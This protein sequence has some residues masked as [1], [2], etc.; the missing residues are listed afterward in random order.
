MHQSVSG[1][2]RKALQKGSPCTPADGSQG[3]AAATMAGD[4]DLA[5]AEALKHQAGLKAQI[6]LEEWHVS[7]GLRAYSA[8]A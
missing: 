7:S 3:G 2:R 4:T 6:W 8:F 1:D 5:E